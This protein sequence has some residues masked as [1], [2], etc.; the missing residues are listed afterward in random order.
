MAPSTPADA[1]GLMKT[2]LREAG[3]VVY[4]DHKRLFPIAGEV[5]AD[6]R[7]SR[8]GEAVLRRRGGD[9][10]ASSPTRT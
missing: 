6:A 9:V 3:P 8:I 7:R 10:D 1:Y 5:A 4:V 2:A